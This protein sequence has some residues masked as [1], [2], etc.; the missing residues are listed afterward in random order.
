MLI[1][2]GKGVATIQEGTEWRFQKAEKDALVEWFRH[3]SIP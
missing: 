3:E 1:G 2:D